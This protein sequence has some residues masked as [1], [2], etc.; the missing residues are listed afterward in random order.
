MISLLPWRTVVRIV[1]R[2]LKILLPVG[3]S[4]YCSAARSREAV[5]PSTNGSRG[6]TPEVV[7]DT[8]NRAVTGSINLTMVLGAQGRAVGEQRSIIL[9]LTSII[10]QVLIIAQLL[11]EQE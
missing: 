2:I 11:S 3:P 7:A 9:T 4:S 5:T 1:T 6:R 8:V 10:A